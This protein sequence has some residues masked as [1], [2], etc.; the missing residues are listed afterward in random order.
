MNWTGGGVSAV[1]SGLGNGYKASV[2]PENIFVS[3]SV[4]HISILLTFISCR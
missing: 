1:S 3:Q 4:L 2:K